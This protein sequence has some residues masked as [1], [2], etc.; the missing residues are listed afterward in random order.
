MNCGVGHR[1]SLDL[2]LLWLWRR[3][4]ATAWIRPLAWKPL[5]AVSAALKGQKTKKK[6]GKKK[7][8][9]KDRRKKTF[10]APRKNGHAMVPMGTSDNTQKG[11]N[12]KEA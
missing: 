1:H 11:P 10:R 2:V 7:T 6:G 3:P 8:W 4:A 12:S 9:G 5:H